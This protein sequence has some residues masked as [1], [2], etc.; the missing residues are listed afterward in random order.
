MSKHTR[1]F[2][3]KRATQEVADVTLIRDSLMSTLR[4]LTLMRGS[5]LDMAVC[6]AMDVLCHAIADYDSPEDRQATLDELAVLMPLR[7]KEIL[8]GPTGPSAH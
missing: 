6:A 7:I 5:S 8:I 4:V 2:S 3:E 1:P